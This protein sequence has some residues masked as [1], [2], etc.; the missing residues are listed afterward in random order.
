MY[1][2]S[3]AVSNNYLQVHTLW[4]EDR[5]VPD[6]NT[7]MKHTLYVEDGKV[8]HVLVGCGAVIEVE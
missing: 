5:Q 2:I 8:S 1:R 6:P 7:M 3:H 4:I